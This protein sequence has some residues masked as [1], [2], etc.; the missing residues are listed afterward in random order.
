M[1]IIGDRTGGGSGVPQGSELPIGW[2]INY[3][4]SQGMTPDGVIFEDG[5]DPDI[6]VDMTAAGIEMGVDEILER[7]LAELP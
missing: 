1:T 3:S 4:G 7:A 2:S 6:F 5:T